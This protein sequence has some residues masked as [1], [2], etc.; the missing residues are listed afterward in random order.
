LDAAELQPT[1]IRGETAQAILTNHFVPAKFEEREIRDESF[2]P[3]KLKSLLYVPASGELLPSD[4]H[5]SAQGSIRLSPLLFDEGITIL[6]ENGLQSRFPEPFK[7]WKSRNDSEKQSIDSAGRQE[8][9][10]AI[11]KLNDEAA[12]M[13]PMLREIIVDHL[14]QSFPWGSFVLSLICN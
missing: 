14:L 5:F 10:E 3:V 2:S 4:L 8:E 7:A 6:M 12:Q 1:L 13:G 11:K 9:Q